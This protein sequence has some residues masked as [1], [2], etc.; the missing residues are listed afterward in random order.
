MGGDQPSTGHAP[1]TGPA[2]WYDHSAGPAVLRP[3]LDGTVVTEC[4]VIG[5][6]LAGLSVAR[7]LARLAVVLLEADRLGAGASGRNGGFVTG[8]F[9]LGADDLVAQAGLDEARALLRLSAAGAESV[10]ALAAQAPGG[11]LSV[12]M[13]D[14][15]LLVL[16]APDRDGLKAYAERQREQFGTASNFL[17]TE[18]VRAL[19]RSPRYFQGLRLGAG[20]HVH[21]LRLV[22]AVAAD[23]EQHGA[24][25][26]EGS[27]V[28]TIGR[29]GGAHVVAT[30]HGRVRARHVVVCTSADDRDLVPEVGRAVLPVATYVAVTE[31]LGAKVDAAIATASAIA[32]TRRAGDYYRRVDGD[33]MGRAHHHHAAAAP[34]PR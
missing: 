17:E 5:G 14:G 9:A 32:D 30:R 26:H 8:G 31:P 2:T 22:R 16:R 18:E 24:I 25:L 23:A 6:G 21:P 1:I 7:E 27:R 29:A 12:R 20:F 10:A 13:G 19:A 33:R 11:A 4:C 3:A 34:P 15:V 28:F